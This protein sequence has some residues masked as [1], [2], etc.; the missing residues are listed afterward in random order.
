ML[1]YWPDAGIDYDCGGDIVIFGWRCNEA[2]IV[3]HGL[4]LNTIAAVDFT[5]STNNSHPLGRLRNDGSAHSPVLDELRRSACKDL[6]IG[7]WLEISAHTLSRTN[8]SE[9]SSVAIADP[10]A[11]SYYSPRVPCVTRVEDASGNLPPGDVN[12]VLYSRTPGLAV[13]P[14]YCC[15]HVDCSGA[16]LAVPCDT[17]ATDVVG[18]APATPASRSHYDTVC[19]SGICSFLNGAGRFPD[20]AGEQ[21]PVRPTTSATTSLPSTPDPISSPPT[22][23]QPADIRVPH[24]RGKWSESMEQPAIQSATA[25]THVKPRSIGTTITQSS[26][27]NWRWFERS[28]PKLTLFIISLYAAVISLSSHILLWLSISATW[29]QL[30]F[31]WSSIQII[32]RAIW[33]WSSAVERSSA[34]SSVFP[35]SPPDSGPR[36]ASLSPSTATVTNTHTDAAMTN[37]LS[38]TALTGTESADASATRAAATSA[39]RAACSLALIQ[40]VDAVSVLLI[41]LAAVPALLWVARTFFAAPAHLYDFSIL[42]FAWLTSIGPRGMLSVDTLRSEIDFLMGLPIGLKLNHYLGKRIGGALLIIV[43]LWFSEG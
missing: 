20:G 6:R 41:D 7:V 27:C 3:S 17:G 42:S 38:T 9:C 8:D 26:C 40:F 36:H 18:F 22:Q 33:R 34:S 14:R 16:R 23:Q 11:L 30:A 10:S 31:K 2:L 15:I 4:P 24:R 37:T 32:A 13:Y 5:T 39:T 35:V 12:V 25:S 28:A 29:R 21:Q 19:V 43:D 1:L